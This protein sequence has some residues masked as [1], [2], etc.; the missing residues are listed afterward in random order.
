MFGDVME[1]TPFTNAAKAAS[2]DGSHNANYGG[3]RSRL[4]PSETSWYF[5]RC[6]PAFLK[7]TLGHSDRSGTMNNDDPRSIAEAIFE[8]KESRETAI[9]DALKLEEERHAAVIKNMRRL[10]ALRLS[11]KQPNKAN[12]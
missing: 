3:H 6:S 9:N 11:R 5:K 12:E 1:I 10:R 8:P 7:A 2:A 4:S